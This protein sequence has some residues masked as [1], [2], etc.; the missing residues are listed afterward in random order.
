MRVRLGRDEGVALPPLQG[1]G[2]TASE[3]SELCR[4]LRKPSVRLVSSSGGPE[5]RRGCFLGTTTTPQA[6]S[7]GARQPPFQGGQINRGPKARLFALPPLQGEV[8]RVSEPEG[9][10]LRLNTPQPLRGSLP[11]ISRLPDFSINANWYEFLNGRKGK[12]TQLKQRQ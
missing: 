8:V 5:G 4:V 10:F 2:Q 7:F 6:R 1:D 11:C 12:K 3:R 9:L